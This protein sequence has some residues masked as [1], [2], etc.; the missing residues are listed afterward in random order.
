MKLETELYLKQVARLPKIGQQII[1]Q[2]QDGQMVVYQ[3]FNPLI[4]SYAVRNQK[5]GGNHYNFDR[6]SWIKPNFLWMMY[7]A[8]WAMKEH[9]EN[10]LAIWLPV[11]K[12]IEIFNLAIHSSFVS[13]IYETED[14]W[15][16]KLQNSTVRLQW[17]PDHDPFG[18]KI[19]R[20]AVQLGLK[21]ET[22]YK[23]GTEWQT[24]IEDITDF[25][26]NEYQKVL[27]NNLDELLVPKENI[28]D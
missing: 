26:K 3:A 13:K 15:K 21:G 9:Q 28:I 14:A 7:R 2:V 11:E 5:F 18:N 22:L 27:A 23:F 4:A 12:F 1:G 25:V 16:Q 19:E 24:K 6:M 8:G 17:D 10:I 20:R